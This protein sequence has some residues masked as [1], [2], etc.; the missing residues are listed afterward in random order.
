TAPGACRSEIPAHTVSLVPPVTLVP[1]LCLG[2]HVL[3]ALLP[4]CF[5]PRSRASHPRVPKQS[6][7]TRR[8]R[9][10][11]LSGGLDRF[12]ITQLRQYALGEGVLEG[13][14]DIP[15][16][17]AVEDARITGQADVPLA[18]RTDRSTRQRRHQRCW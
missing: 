3:E 11:S 2:T 16:L 4:L 12:E 1:K 6:L 17:V 14:Q 15:R 9:R 5:L 13:D 18:I 8:T 10:Y 7:G